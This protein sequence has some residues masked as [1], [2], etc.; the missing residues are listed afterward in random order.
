MADPKEQHEIRSFLGLCTHYRRFISCFT[1]TAKPP[2]KLAEE[3]QAFQSTPE[4]KAAFQTPKEALCTA[5]Y[6]QSGERFIVDR[7]AGNVRTGGV[8]S[9][10][11]DGQE[12][13]T[14]YYSKT[15]NKVSEITASPNGNYLQS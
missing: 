14:A 9:Q 1:N 2:T 7:D 4:M 5:P 13:V 15:L 11:Q 10:I 12:Q 8:L 3:K 6:P